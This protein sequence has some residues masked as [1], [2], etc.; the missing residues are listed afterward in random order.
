MG[1]VAAGYFLLVCL[2][3]F[4]FRQIGL[5][6]VGKLLPE[7]AAAGLT[8]VILALAINQRKT[9]I[10]FK[11]MVWAMFFVIALI[12]GAFTNQV[13]TGAVV[14]GIREYFKY[15][16]LFLLPLVYEFSEKDLR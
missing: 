12:C 8:I 2:G 9:A 3:D 16:P 1:Y 6:Q 11:Y 7:A 5:V 13:N 14:F 15:A 10:P 4:A